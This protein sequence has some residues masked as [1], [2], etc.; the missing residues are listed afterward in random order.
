MKDKVST[1]LPKALW[2]ELFDQMDDL[3]DLILNI[4]SKQTKNTKILVESPVS[5]K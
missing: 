1:K 2:Q 3:H 5:N 4:K